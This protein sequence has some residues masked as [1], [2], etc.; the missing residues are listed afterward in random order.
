[1]RAEF[2]SKLEDTVGKEWVVTRREVMEDY[3]VDETAPAVRPKPAADVVL[4]KPDS[5]QEISNIL[6]LANEEKVPV[7]PRGG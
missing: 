5:A 6:K 2:I 7:F 1:M 4:V 3:L